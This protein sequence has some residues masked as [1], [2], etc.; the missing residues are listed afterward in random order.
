MCRFDMQIGSDRSPLRPVTPVPTIGIWPFRE[1]IPEAL[2]RVLVFAVI[3]VRV[4]VHV[5]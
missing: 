2:I 4:V 3:S 1:E 5:A